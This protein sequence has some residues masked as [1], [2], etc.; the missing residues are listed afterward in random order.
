MGCGVLHLSGSSSSSGGR[1][2]GSVRVNGGIGGE[3]VSCDN[4]LLVLFHLVVL[5][6]VAIV[7]LIVVVNV[8][9]I[10]LSGLGEVDDLAASAR[11]DNV[12]QIDGVFSVT[13]VLVV[14]LLGCT[15]VLLDFYK[16]ASRRGLSDSESK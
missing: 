7:L 14:I 9:G 6:K 4:R 5:L 8:G 15:K 10:L 13:L 12:V 16:V 2:L 11:G 1:R 3:S